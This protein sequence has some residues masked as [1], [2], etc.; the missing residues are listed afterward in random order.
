MNDVGISMYITSH[1][2]NYSSDFLYF[3]T[4]FNPGLFFIEKIATIPTPIRYGGLFK[5][6]SL[7]IVQY[8]AH[9]RMS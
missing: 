8:I 5:E 9:E 2:R 3:S 1:S 4:K 7:K 6:P